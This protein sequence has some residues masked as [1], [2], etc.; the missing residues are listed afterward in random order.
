MSHGFRTQ[1]VLQPF[2]RFADVVRGEELARLQVD[3]RG[4]SYIATVMVWIHWFMGAFGI[5]QLVYRPSYGPRTFAAYIVLLIS[6]YALNAYIHYML[7]SGKSVTWRWIFALCAG[8]ILAVSG[9]IVISDGFDHYFLHLLYYPS[10]ALFAA[11]FAS[12]RVNM[13]WV[14][15]VCAGYVVIS[16]TAGDGLD[17][18]ARDEK[19]LLMRVATMYAVVATV[20][21]VSNFERVRWADAARRERTLQRERTE[22]SR[23]IHDTV[24]Q[25]AYMVG[26][27][28]DRVRALAGSG[29]GELTAAI[30]ETRRISQST[31]WELR[32]PIDIGRIFEGVELGETLRSHA[33]S[34][35]NI[36]SVPAEFTETGAEPPLSAEAR[37]LLFSA[38]HN[39]LT[40]A[41]RHAR[42]TSV[43]IELGFSDEAVRLSVMDDGIGLPDDYGE[44]GNGFRNM[45][46]VAERLGGHLEV[47][48]RGPLGGAAVTCVIPAGPHLA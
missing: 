43:R 23:T 28:I 19:P 14:T 6:L 21:L 17:F 39:A 40:N 37:S 27:G 34:F 15:L 41:Y 30:D 31:V 10:L 11:V 36:T 22:L 13:A 20:N 2:A 32:Q 45:R 25:S 9:A 16:L 4:L 18:S 38:A 8:D 12:F 44:R 7:V 3:P 24:A 29:D 35:T 26:L 33:T 48:R 46:G 42:P 5:Y 1:Q 47:E